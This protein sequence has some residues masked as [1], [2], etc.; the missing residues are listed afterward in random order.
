VGERFAS[1]G[2]DAHKNQIAPDHFNYTILYN[3]LAIMGPLPQ[4]RMYPDGREYTLA[5]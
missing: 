4:V 1:A 5:G 3:A 2:L